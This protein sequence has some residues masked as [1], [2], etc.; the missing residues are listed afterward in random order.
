METLYDSLDKFVFARGVLNGQDLA[1]E[2]EIHSEIGE[3]Y[4]AYLKQEENAIFERSIQL[5]NTLKPRIMTTEPWFKRATQRLL[6]IQLERTRKTDLATEA[7]RQARFYKYKEEMKTK[8]EVLK[9]KS[10]AN[11]SSPEAFVK[12]LYETHKPKGEKPEIK[13]DF[14]L[15]NI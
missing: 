15:K 10:E 12:F 8:L 9:T 3:V 2:A 14:S 4:Y 6:E 13:E 1:I 11:E 5:A 7:E